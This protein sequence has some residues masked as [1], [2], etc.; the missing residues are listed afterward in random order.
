[1]I[2]FLVLMMMM[3]A[4]VMAQ[5]VVTKMDTTGLGIMNEELR[6]TRSS[7]SANGASI[8][9]LQAD[10]T[11]KFDSSTGHD[12]DGTD[13]KKVPVGNLDATDISVDNYL[14]NDAGTIK[15][16]NLPANVFSLISTTTITSATESAQIPIDSSKNYVAYLVG[17]NDQSGSSW[18]IT[19]SSTTAKTIMSTSDA[20]V[21]SAEVKIF[22]TIGSGNTQSWFTVANNYGTTLTQTAFNISNSTY[23]TFSSTNTFS[24]YVYLYEIGTN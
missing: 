5:E 10:I 19:P 7:T 21:V 11:S 20:R 22:K 13:S 6:R 23:F 14:Y 9:S 16:K 12:H 1:M 4:P 17:T 2:R 8:V 3:C 24:G 15:G 18:Y